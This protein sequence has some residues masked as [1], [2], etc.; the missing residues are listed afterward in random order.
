LR[1]ATLRRMARTMR[2]TLWRR[3]RGKGSGKQYT[4]VRGGDTGAMARMRVRR[5]YSP[6]K[7]RLGVMVR[8]LNVDDC[9]LHFCELLALHEALDVGLDNHCDMPHPA[10]LHHAT[11]QKKGKMVGVGP[12]GRV[13]RVCVCGGN[14][15]TRT[16]ASFFAT[17]TTFS[18]T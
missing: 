4:M 9:L 6:A 15:R 2:I 11:K 16:P 17:H 8:Y 12:Q 7:A 18:T 1:N 3:Q 10:L 14:M 5:S 13:R